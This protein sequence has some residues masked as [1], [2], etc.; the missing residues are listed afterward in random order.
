MVLIVPKIAKASAAANDIDTLLSY[1]KPSNESHGDR[2]FPIRGD[3]T[4]DHVNFAYPQRA[5]APV[6]NGV[7]FT[8][9]DGECV[10][11]VGPSGSG[12][13]TIAALLQRL[14]EPSS[15]SIKL[16]KFTLNETDVVWL[17][18]HM[19]VV[20]QQPALFDSSI[21]DNITYGAGG[22]SVPFEEIQRAARDANLDDFIESLPNGYDTLLGENASLISGGQ[23][24]RIQ[25]ARAL[26][27]GKA[28]ILLLDEFTSAL[29]PNNQESLMATVMKLKEERTTIIVTHKVPVMRK[30][31]RL[32]VVQDGQIVEEG[33]YESLI[34]RK[35]VFWTMVT[36]G[37]LA[38][39]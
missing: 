15:G 17:R 10:G 38:T 12:K 23:A 22:D 21:K 5:D 9:H 16:G 36:A 35:G 27:N 26:V 8:I 1:S 24:Q 34:R 18:S 7:S 33:T 37:D 6:L 3:L 2:R 19:A 13:S 14:Y 20:S 29:D 11:V 4:F 32:I 30:C 28:N 31:D 25:L 39:E